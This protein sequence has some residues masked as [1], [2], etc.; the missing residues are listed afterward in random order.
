M[1]DAAAGWYDQGDGRQRYW[2]GTAWTEHFAPANPAAVAPTTHGATAQPPGLA[3]TPPRKRRVW[4]SIVGIGGRLLLLAIGVVVLFVVVLNKASEGP[5]EA[6]HDFD[7]AWR[8]GDC[9]LLEETT[10]EAYRDSTGWN[11]CE[12]FK[13]SG[14]A[15]TEGLSLDIT[16][17]TV[18]GDSATVTTTEKYPEED[19]PLTG[20]YD[21]VKVGGD[22][23]IDSVTLLD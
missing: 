19:A 18:S 3:A 12:A 6:V 16:G 13:A 4:P 11:D 5:R 7:T 1:A 21:L 14:P 17:F 22:W 8:T 23:K 2:D 10:T 20:S 15:T 9:V